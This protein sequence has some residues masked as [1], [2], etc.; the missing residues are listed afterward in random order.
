MRVV[1][2]TNVLISGVIATGTPHDVLVA[3]YNGEYQIVV[4]VPTL[5]EF[6]KTLQKYPDG[7]VWTRRKSSRKS[8]HSDTTRSLSIQTQISAS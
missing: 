5:T 1:L 6:R 7:S 3:G 2:D 8:K 4:S